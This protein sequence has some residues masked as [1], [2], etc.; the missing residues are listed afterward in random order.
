MSINHGD[1][2]SG[3]RSVKKKFP[4]VLRFTQMFLELSGTG[5]E[6]VIKNL[7][8][9]T[10]DWGKKIEETQHLTSAGALLFPGLHSRLCAVQ[11]AKSI[12]EGRQL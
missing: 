12:S 7:Q 2:M 9:V 5:G 4:R 3:F 11:E 1:M 8:P 6:T 10:Q